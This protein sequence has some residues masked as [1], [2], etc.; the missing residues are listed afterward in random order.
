MSFDSAT[1][2]Q[3]ARSVHHSRYDLATLRGREQSVSVCLPARN[4]AATVGAIVEALVSLRDADLLEQIVVIDGDSQDG[5]R[6]IAADF[7][8]TVWRESELMADY[9]PVLGKGD[10]MWRALS[11]VEG[12]LVCFLDADIEEFPLHYVTGLLGPLI[13]LPDV[14]FVKAFYRKSF[15]VGGLD[16]AD[17]GGRVNHLVAR[18]ALAIFYP[19]LAG[20]SQPLAGEVA[21]SRALLER[22][23][24]TTGY[25]VE[26]AMLLDVLAQIGLDG[27]A[28]VDLDVQH[29][30]HQSL[31]ALSA[32][33]YEV[34]AVI[35]R[36]LEREGRLN[37]L[38][39]SQLLHVSAP[40]PAPRPTVERPPMVSVS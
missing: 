10:A 39:P 37:D 6:E 12:D 35:A 16:L 8:A 4:C 11:V 27:M 32:M 26:V 30:R 38:D 28:Q 18:P 21:A 36:R 25:G 22:L 19:E 3:Q 31:L 9:G 14:E 20:V 2:W 40:Q 17:G 24:F 34:L 13:E 1:A 5:T 23:P 29:N 33:A 7:G 15:R